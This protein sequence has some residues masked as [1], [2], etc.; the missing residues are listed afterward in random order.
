MEA[1]DYI[2]VDKRLCMNESTYAILMVSFRSLKGADINQ[3][4]EI[5]RLE[6]RKYFQ[7]QLQKKMNRRTG[8]VDE[9]QLNLF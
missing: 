2:W 7:Y 1:R 9:N 5:I 3:L 6:T 4:P 8:Q